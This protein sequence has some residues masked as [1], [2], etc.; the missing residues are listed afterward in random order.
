MPRRRSRPSPSDREPRSDTLETGL[1]TTSTPAGQRPTRRPWTPARAI[2]AAATGTVAYT[3]PVFLTGALAVQL[4]G[5]LA[6]G[7]A[8]IGVGVGAFRGAAAL[9]SV[10]MGRLVDRLGAIG[11]LRLAAGIATVAS[12]GLALTA[13]D[14]RSMA[15]WLIL[16]GSANA[17]GQPAANRL[18]HRHVPP[19]RQGLAFGVKQAAVPSA[20]MLAGLAVPAVALTVGWRWAFAAPGALAIALASLSAGVGSRTRL[21]RRPP[22]DAARAEDRRSTRLR[23]RRTVVLL[24]CALGLGMAAASTAPAFFVDAA[25]TTGVRPSVAGFVLAAASILTVGSR[26]LAGIVT[27]RL[28]G[29]QLRICAG[30]AFVGAF[31]FAALASGDPALLVVGILVAMAGGWGFNGVFWYC[32]VRAYPET[33]GRATGAVAPGGLLGASLGP[34]MFGAVV[35]RT[36]YAAGWTLGAVF[37]VAAAVTML[38]AAR[39]LRPEGPSRG[40]V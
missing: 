20:T 8:G 21:A 31:G 7:I 1:S 33:P 27:D 35:E 2:L 13:V 12:A 23:D 38:L 34:V 29:G 37:A 19:A 14:L 18:L 26:L 40:A 16:A 3:L 11:S 25:V 10:H 4:T 32:L 39:R 36:S 30:M 22:S 28:A 6:F 9:S 15:A 17:I 5:E 24:S